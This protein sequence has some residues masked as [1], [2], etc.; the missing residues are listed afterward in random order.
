[1]VLFSYVDL[2]HSTA[3]SS[4]SDI[5]LPATEQEGVTIRTSCLT[6]VSF[7]ELWGGQEHLRHTG[8][9]FVC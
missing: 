5:Y 9:K 6:S 8:T 7:R 2:N 1:M 3:L 4:D